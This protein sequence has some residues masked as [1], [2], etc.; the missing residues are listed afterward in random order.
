MQRD[1]TKEPKKAVKEP[2]QL[3][4]TGA[5]VWW[6][7][8]SICKPGPKK[9]KV[10]HQRLKFARLGWENF[11]LVKMIILVC[12]GGQLQDIL[13]LCTTREKLYNLLAEKHK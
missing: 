12:W 8:Q 2:I 11:V 1:R 10:T 7:T 13:E 4:N 6:D 3:D 9:K 5:A